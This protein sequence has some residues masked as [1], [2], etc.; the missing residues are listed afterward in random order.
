MAPLYG[1]SRKGERVYDR[2]PYER[3]TNLTTIGAISLS[4][5]KG[6][7]TRAKKNLVRSHKGKKNSGCNKCR[8]TQA[9]TDK[10]NIKTHYF[11]HPHSS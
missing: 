11:L 3:G 2:R 1:R 4:G 7:M 8:Q 10:L 6:I 9:I 5:F